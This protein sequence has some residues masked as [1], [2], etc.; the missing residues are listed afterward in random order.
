MFI[1]PFNNNFILKLDFYKKKRDN[2]SISQTEVGS[3][4]EQ[5][6]RDNLMQAHQDDDPKCKTILNG[7]HGCKTILNGL[8]SC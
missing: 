6:T 7:L 5:P 2:G 8:H 4:E 1:P 3:A